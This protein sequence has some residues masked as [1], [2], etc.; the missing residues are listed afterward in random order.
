LKTS[1]FFAGTDI[2][3][4]DVPESPIIEVLALGFQLGFGTL[5]PFFIIVV[6]NVWIINTVSESMVLLLLTQ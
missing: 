5:I 1:S 4:A 2:L 3:R 6:S